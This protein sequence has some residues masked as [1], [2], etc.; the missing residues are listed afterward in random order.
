MGNT[1]PGQFRGRTTSKN[2]KLIQRTLI[3]QVSLTFLTAAVV[4]LTAGQVA[5]YSALLGGLIYLVP[6]LYQVKQVFSTSDSNNIRQILRDLYKSEIWKMALTIVLFGVVFS[7]VK[8]IEPFSIFG[9]FILMQL[10][11]WITPLSQASHR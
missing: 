11:A 3:I 8:P 7:T 6:N 1:G 2:R 4:L 5:A 10:V 9:V